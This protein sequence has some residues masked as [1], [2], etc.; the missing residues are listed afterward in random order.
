MHSKLSQAYH[1]TPPKAL[2]NT[3]WSINMQQQQLQGEGFSSF[4]TAIRAELEQTGNRMRRYEDQLTM[5]APRN[6]A[7]NRGNHLTA[8]KNRA[9]NRQKHLVSRVGADV[10]SVHV[11]SQ[12]GRDR[13]RTRSHHAGRRFLPY[14]V[15]VSRTTWTGRRARGGH[16]EEGEQ[17]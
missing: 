6:R 7:G 10:Y 14:S 16:Q 2:S 8:P 3:I 15:L 9:S 4:K 1:V 5:M 12:P 11:R 17:R 13:Q